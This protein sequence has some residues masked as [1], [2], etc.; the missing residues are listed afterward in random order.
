MATFP[1]RPFRFGVLSYPACADLAAQARRAE[2]LGYDTYHLSDHFMCIAPIAAM[3]AAALATTKIR[4]GSAVLGNDFWHP[5]VLARELLAIDCISNGR[6][7]FGLGSGW[8][9]EDYKQTGID[10]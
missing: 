7:E 1:Q 6:L 9:S 5:A 3:T 2:E 10:G 8:Y 4:I